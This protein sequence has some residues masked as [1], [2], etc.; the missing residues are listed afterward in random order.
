MKVT[1]PLHVGLKPFRCH[2]RVKANP[3]AKPGYCFRVR[4]ERASTGTEHRV[5]FWSTR[6]GKPVG[7]MKG[8]CEFTPNKSEAHVWNVD[9]KFGAEWRVR[10]CIEVAASG[11]GH[12]DDVKKARALMKALKK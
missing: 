7:W 12:P 3:K 2:G 9:N 10:D 11:K 8:W 5:E 1:L 4:T 6:T